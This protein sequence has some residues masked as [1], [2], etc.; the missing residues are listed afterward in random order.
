M[1]LQFWIDNADSLPHQIFMIVMGVLYAMAF[2]LG[3]SYKALN[4]YVYF[5][6]FPLSFALFLKNK[7]KFLVL[8][9]SFLFFLIPGF[10]NLS[11]K[12]FDDCV[13]FLNYMAKNLNSN[14]I[15]MSIYLCVFVPILFY[16]PFLIKYFGLQYF[17]YGMYILAVLGV[18][19]MIFIYPNFKDVLISLQSHKNFKI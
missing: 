10:E 7:W 8:P 6:V 18:I 9:I 3:I 11:V 16:I 15:N 4:I 19:Y 12:F 5:I 2:V 1:N 14:Y 13:V 17:K